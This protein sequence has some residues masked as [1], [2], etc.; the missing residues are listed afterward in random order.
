[1]GLHKEENIWNILLAS[2]ES[3]HLEREL[4][5]APGRA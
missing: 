1:M 3:I 4:L 5:Y 2:N